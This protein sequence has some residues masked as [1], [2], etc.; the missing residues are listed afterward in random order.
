MAKSTYRREDLG[1]EIET[2]SGY[3]QPVE[4]RFLEYRGRRLLYV[5]GCACIEASCCGVG[6]WSYARVEGYLGE[7]DTPGSEALRTSVEVETV[8]DGEDKAAIARLLA[9]KHPGAKVEFR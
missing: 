5:L 3:Y 1:S 8:E 6:S 7:G 2:P 9:E 4:E